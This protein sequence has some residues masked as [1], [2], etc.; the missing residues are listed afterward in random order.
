M[1][2]PGGVEGQR[3]AVGVTAEEAVGCAEPVGQPSHFGQSLHDL[4]RAHSHSFL[5]V[6][7]A[8]R[9]ND[10]DHDPRGDEA[11]VDASKSIAGGMA[12][13]G[14]PK[15]ATY[16]LKDFHGH[17]CKL[18]S[19][20]CRALRGRALLRPRSGR[21]FPRAAPEPGGSFSRD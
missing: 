14:A 10:D 11:G 5:I 15:A 3:S 13:P 19:R 18:T 8:R 17:H 2:H 9:R 21:P 20:P 4:Q 16:D 7:A 12:D 1:E 6:T